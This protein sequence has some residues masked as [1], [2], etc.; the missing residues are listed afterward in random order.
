MKFQIAATILL[1]SIAELCSS[2]S[3]GV[4]V[5]KKGEPIHQLRIY[6]I[7]GKNKNAFHER[8]RDHAMRIMDKY[9]FNIIATWETSHK[10]STAFVYLLEWPDEQTMR[11]KW[12][13]FMKDQEWSAIKKETGARHGQMVGGITDRILKSTDYSPKKHFQ[14]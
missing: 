4:D 8:F 7:F 13:E 2:Q 14:N 10:D 5:E 6:E 9:G 11:T 12:S 1:L 3:L